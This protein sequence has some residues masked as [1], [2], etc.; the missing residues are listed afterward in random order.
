MLSSRKTRFRWS[1]QDRES[2]Q[3]LFRAMAQQ[4]HPTVRRH[5]PDPEE[6]PRLR[7]RPPDPAGNEAPTWTPWLWID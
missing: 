4:W 2:D 3:P 6:T 5:A 7:T 1:K